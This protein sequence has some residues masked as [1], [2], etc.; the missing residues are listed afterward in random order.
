MA[1]HFLH[2]AVLEELAV[3]EAEAAIFEV[4]GSVGFGAAVFLLCQGHPPQRSNL[5][6][7]NMFP[8]CRSGSPESVPAQG[9]TAMSVPKS[10]AR[11]QTSG[12]SVSLIPT[13]QDLRF[14][15]T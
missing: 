13:E 9:S 15:L 14:P 6:A 8:Q 11:R 7:G 1:Y 4:G 2:R 5:L 3:L 12:T 10:P